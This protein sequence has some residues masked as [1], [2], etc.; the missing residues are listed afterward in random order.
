MDAGFYCPLDD[1]PLHEHSHGQ[2]GTFLQ[3][4]SCSG[5]WV[6]RLFLQGLAARR[7]DQL[8]GSL[9]TLPPPTHRPDS[10]NCPKCNYLMVQRMQG[11]VQMD[12]CPDCK[13]VW[14]DGGE[15]VRIGNATRQK[16]APKI[17]GRVSAMA[18]YEHKRGL[19]ENPSS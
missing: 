15:I 9:E 17:Q 10:I 8:M 1:S 13:A 11:S 12:I 16:N 7:D 19:F 4:Q 6:P 5:I 2:G 18:S 3:C 14:L